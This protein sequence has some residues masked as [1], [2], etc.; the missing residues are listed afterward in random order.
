MVTKSKTN[1]I[2]KKFTDVATDARRVGIFLFY[3]AN[4]ALG[5][6]EAEKI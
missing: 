1:K 2:K 5:T 6:V 4:L 3:E